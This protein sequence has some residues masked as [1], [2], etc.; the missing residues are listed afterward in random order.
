M[1][2]SIWGAFF[3]GAD[4]LGSVLQG[5][6]P[7]AFCEGDLGKCFVREHC[8]GFCE[9]ALVVSFATKC[10][11]SVLRWNAPG[12]FCDRTLRERFVQRSGSVLQQNSWGVFYTVECLGSVMRWMAPADCFEWEL[13]GSISQQDAQG[14]F[15]KEMLWEHF[16]RRHSESILQGEA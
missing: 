13:P 6:A 12:A 10:L 16:T 5:N 11:G 4:H 8:G 2:G 3:K 14:A 1:Q 7:G 9:G 15:C